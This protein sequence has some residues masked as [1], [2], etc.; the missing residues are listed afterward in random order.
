[1]RPANLQHAFETKE[2]ARGTAKCTIFRKHKMNA[3]C[4]QAKDQ[5]KQTIGTVSRSVC[6]GSNL[7]GWDTISF[8]YTTFLNTSHITN[9]YLENRIKE[10]HRIFRFPVAWLFWLRRLPS[11][12]LRSTADGLFQ[13]LVTDDVIGTWWVCFTWIKQNVQ[14]QNKSLAN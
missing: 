7:E 5:K 10:V 12:A 3:P 6:A 4:L 9:G 8:P 13:F 1:M 11:S 14:C 2:M